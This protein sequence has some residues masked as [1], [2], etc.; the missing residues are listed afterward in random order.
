M[1]AKTQQKEKPGTNTA[2][3]KQ[4]QGWG[5]KSAD[6]LEIEDELVNTGIAFINFQNIIDCLKDALF[7]D[8]ETTRCHCQKVRQWHEKEIKY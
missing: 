1:S 5:R 4:K 6:L 2:V 8:W 3:I 7:G